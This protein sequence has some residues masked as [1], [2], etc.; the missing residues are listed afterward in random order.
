MSMLRQLIRPRVR[1]GI[2]QPVTA[3]STMYIGGGASPS[4]RCRVP[5]YA[6]SPSM[7]EPQGSKRFYGHQHKPVPPRLRTADTWR[8]MSKTVSASDTADLGHNSEVDH[9]AAAATNGTAESPKHDVIDKLLGL[10]RLQPLEADDRPKILCEFVTQAA[11]NFMSCGAVAMAKMYAGSDAALTM[12]LIMG[13]HLVLLP[14]MI[15]TAGPISGAHFNPM[16][17][18][19]FMMARMQSVSSGVCYIIAQCLGGIF[20]AA[21][22]FYSLPVS[23]QNVGFAGVQG[24]P[25]DRTVAQ[26]FLGEVYASF[27]FVFV[28][29]GMLVDKRGWGKLGPLAVPLAICL[30]MWILGP[31]SSMCI[32]PARALG[33]A[34]VTGFWENHWLWWTA[35]FVGG[36]TAGK[37]YTKFWLPKDQLPDLAKKAINKVL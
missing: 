12:G 24:V 9:K 29:F 28:L 5:S 1:H 34:V 19:V 20:G 26:A 30:D 21:G 13:A 32:N 31:V 27:F 23:M 33:P 2:I 3:L 16:V 6:T 10:F 15:Y 36:L 4:S 22:A 18:S 11:F 35:P 8:H 14:V 25:L 17:T 37:L 7:S